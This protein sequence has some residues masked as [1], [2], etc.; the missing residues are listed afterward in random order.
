MN[1]ERNVQVERSLTAPPDRVFSACV[2]PEQLSRWWG[3]AG[4]SV[5][6]AELDVRQGGRYRIEM[7][8]PEGEP[9]YLQGE[10]REVDPPGRL[11]YTFEWDPATPDDHETLVVLTFEPN[12]AGTRLLLHHGPFAT[13]ERYALHA[14]GW[15]D[16]LD[17][18]ED[19]LAANPAQPQADSGGYPLSGDSGLQR[20]ADA[21]REDEV[22]LRLPHDPGGRGG[23]RRRRREAP[24]RREGQQLAGD[25]RRRGEGVAG[26]S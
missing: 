22:A 24:S 15:S 2:E 6:E 14:A 4:F 16:T 7:L 17:R 18:L 8:P 25:R 23:A 5:P 21:D 1:S 19:W 20:A 10:Y 9:F 12:D 26:E 3:P 13:D 11:V